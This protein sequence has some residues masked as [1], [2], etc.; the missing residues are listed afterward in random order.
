MFK[1][2]KSIAC[3][4]ISLAVIIGFIATK[5]AIC[6]WG[7]LFMLFIWRSK[8][9]LILNIKQKEKIMEI[10]KD[11]WIW[12]KKNICFLEKNIILGLIAIYLHSNGLNQNINAKNAEEIWEKILWLFYPL[13]LLNLNINV[14]NVII[15]II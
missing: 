3:I 6:L 4:G 10:G 11:S 2:S 13:I 15:L 1:D 14:I 12:L 9:W 5:N 7:L 8:I